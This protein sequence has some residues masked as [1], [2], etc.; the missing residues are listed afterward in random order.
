MCG[1]FGATE[2][3]RFITLY[4]LNKQRGTFSTSMGITTD[5]GDMIVHRW[6]GSVTSLQAAAELDNS[7][8]IAKRVPR[9]FVGHTQAPTSSKRKYTT[10]TSHPFHTGSWVIAHN[11]VLTNFNEIKEEFDPAW[12]NPVDSSIIPTVLK[13]S[14]KNLEGSSNLQPEVIAKA[15]ALLEGTFGLWIY[16]SAERHLYLARCGS[17]LFADALNNEFSSI[18]FK[19]SEQ[20]DEGIL[21]VLTQE[22]ITPVASFDF[23][24]PFFT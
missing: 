17:T 24:S 22:G 4:E 6:K 7:L 20:L 18:K 12:E 8:K 10:E 19:N 14:Q 15:L 23:N 1:I 13:E 9:Y 5:G 16:E 2:L 11:G 21:Y 3:D